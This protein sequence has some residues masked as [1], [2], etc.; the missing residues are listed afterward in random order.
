MGDFRAVGK[1]LEIIQV[2]KE[3]G[4]T[5]DFV[6]AI[7]FTGSGPEVAFLSQIER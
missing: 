5:F 2:G 6:T 4:G 1:P 7:E 3:R